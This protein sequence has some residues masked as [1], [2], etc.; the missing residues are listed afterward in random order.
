MKD[1]RF[2][3]G[4]LI[5]KKIFKQLVAYQSKV[6]LWQISPESGSRQIT[7]THVNSFN[8][9]TKHL[10]FEHNAR[11]FL[12]AT[13]PVYGYVEEGALIFKTTIEP[14][15]DNNLTLRVPDQISLIQEEEMMILDTIASKVIS[16]IWRSKR[17]DTTA[18]DLGSDFMRVKSMSQRSS[19]DQELLNQEMGLTLDQEDK[20]YADQRESPRARPKDDKWV[21]VMRSQGE[22]PL[23]YRLF[24]LSRGGLGFISAVENEFTKGSLIYVVGFNDYDL[25]DPLIGSIMS[26]RS[27]DGNLGEFKV[28][29][30][31]TEGQD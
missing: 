19:R 2:E 13:L 16:N 11:K 17:L 14:S 28:G 18:D 6:V 8:F 10:Y 26:I 21:K 5:Y 22:M 25:D 3:T 20:L 23:V 4:F 7:E 30:K 12:K 24:D 1:I 29:I 15:S 27:M 31:F 9:E